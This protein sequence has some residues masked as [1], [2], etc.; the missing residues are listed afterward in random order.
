MHNK[1]PIIYFGREQHTPFLCSVFEATVLEPL[2]IIS[3]MFV[4]GYFLRIHNSRRVQ[5]HENYVAEDYSGKIV[6][7]DV[8]PGNAF[9]WNDINYYIIISRAQNMSDLAIDENVKGKID[10]VV[11]ETSDKIR[12][13]PWR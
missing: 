10:S 13:F 4:K 3:K 9:T 7:E 6:E 12:A 5:S 11:S 1:L 2:D 8:P